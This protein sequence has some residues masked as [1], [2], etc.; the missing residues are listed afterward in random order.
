MGKRAILKS[1][2]TGT[3]NSLVNALVGYPFVIPGG[4]AGE[5]PG[6]TPDGLMISIGSLPKGL[7]SIPSQTV[8]SATGMGGILDIFLS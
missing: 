3:A 2:D 8:L 4:A 7:S 5:P 6:I 1:F